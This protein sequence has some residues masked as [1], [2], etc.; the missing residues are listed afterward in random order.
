MSQRRMIIGG[1]PKD[2]QSSARRLLKYLGKNKMLLFVVLCF[3]IITTLCSLYG[4]Y[5]ISPIVQFVEDAYLGKITVEAAFQGIVSL[6][7][8]LAVVYLVE[9]SLTYIASRMMILVSQRTVKLIREEL[10]EK[11]MRIPVS[12]H[13]HYQHGELMSRFTNDIDLV[14]EALNMSAASIVSNV[15][16]LAGTVVLMLILSPILGIITCIILPLLSLLSNKVV[17]YSRKYSKRQQESL[18]ILNGNIEENIEGQSVI[19]LFNHETQSFDQFSNLNQNFKKNAQKAQIASGIMFPLMA[20]MNNVNYAIMGGVGGYLVIQG[21]MSIA[22]L[23]AFVSLTKTLGRPI[24]E[25]AMQFTTLQ[26]A[27]AS[28]ERLFEVLDWPVEES[29]AED[30]ILDK[31]E[32]KVV[33][34]H[35]VFGYNPEIPVL[36]D[37]SFFAKN[38]QKVAF[39]GSTGAGKTTITNLITRFYDIQRGEISIDD[40]S[41]D[42]INRFSLR[43][44]IAMVLQDTHLF[45]GTVMENI[46]YGNLEADDE[47]VIAAAT[48][49]N[50]HLFIEKLEHGYDTIIS[51]DGS[52]L[53]QGQRQLL[54]IARAMIANPEILILDE[55]TSSIDTRTERLIEKGMDRL[56]EGRTTFVI[57]HRLSTVRNANAIL[58]VEHG[59]II[60]RGSH[61]ELLALDGRYA[62]LYY[63][64]SKLN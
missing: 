57:A 52:E 63:G 9:V 41:V 10:F 3:T 62:S 28:A 21:L 61:D 44:H 8:I 19:Q 55:A 51:G 40:I 29:S 17:Q 22:N 35:V 34:D 7:I 48:L 39:V 1:K 23:S 30:I 42:A 20:N 25:I 56:M 31:V 54:N 37:V 49:A 32:G 24:N 46:R 11:V 27:L 2:I 14:S 50:A 13:D 36:K 53:S 18:G 58:V 47:E 16:S 60:E 15:L 43:K 26:S 45:T 12:Y 33:F 5:A 6:L 4:S 59:Q 64:Q 38:G